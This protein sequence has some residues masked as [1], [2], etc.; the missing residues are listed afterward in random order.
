M[1]E[2][3]EPISEAKLLA[4]VDAGRERMGVAEARLWDAIC[5]PPEKWRQH[6]Y[7][8]DGG[9]FWA[10]ALLGRIVVWYNDIEEGFNRS[11]YTT[12]GTIDQYFCN[13]DE[14]QWTVRHL[15]NLLRKG[16]DS[17]VF[18]GPPLPADRPGRE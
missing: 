10:V 16:Y 2:G 6:P 13:Q 7:G 14:L 8:D 5:I 3:W 1:T 11:R 9:G 4:L 15:L 18:A 17:G 12:Y